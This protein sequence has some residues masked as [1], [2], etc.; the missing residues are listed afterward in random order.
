VGTGGEKTGPSF[1]SRFELLAEKN[2]VA[3]ANVGSMVT[4]TAA[5]VATCSDASANAPSAA[6]SDTAC[7][8][9]AVLRVLKEP[10]PL[11]QLRAAREAFRKIAPYLASVAIVARRMPEW[12][13][14]ETEIDELGGGPWVTGLCSSCR[15]RVGVQLPASAAI[16]TVLCPNGHR[17]RVRNLHS[18]GSAHL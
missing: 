3:W 18:A 16:P 1:R 6:A 11:E 17:L 4:V 9:G 13:L 10:A 12:A 5:S 15:E 2:A 14:V 7:N 8:G